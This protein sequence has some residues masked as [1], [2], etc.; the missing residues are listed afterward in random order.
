MKYPDISNILKERE[1]DAGSASLTRCTAR[2][3]ALKLQ[4][5]NR[6]ENHK[7]RLKTKEYKEIM[8]KKELTTDRIC[9]STGLSEFSRNWIL[10]NGGAVF[11]GPV[12]DD[13]H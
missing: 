9:R 8:Q 1:P 5:I 10:D 3:Q 13:P 6:K 12:Q 4:A 7:V 11:S 2:G